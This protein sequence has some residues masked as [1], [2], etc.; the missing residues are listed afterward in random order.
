MYLPLSRN[1]PLRNSTAWGR[2]ASIQSIPRVYGRATI[3]PVPYDDS[4]R[5]FVV[6]D[7]AVQGIT[8]VTADRVA[9]TVHRFF[10]QADTTGKMVAFAELQTAITIGTTAL[11]ATVEGIRDPLTGLLM[12]NPADIAWDLL[13]WATSHS[14]DRNR[15]ARFRGSCQYA[16]LEAHGAL[17]DSS[18]TLRAAL[19]SIMTSSG[20]AWSSAAPDFGLVLV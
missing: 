19:D 18:L 14:V 16:G 9:V 20:V 10:H 11:A 2:F 6:A 5:L 3:T 13:Q 1:I 4:G 8:S 17:V 12:T 7:H 15:F